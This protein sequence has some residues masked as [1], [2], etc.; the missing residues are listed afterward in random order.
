MVFCLNYIQYKV[1]IPS[2]P[3]QNK[4]IFIYGEEYVN[5]VEIE[6]EGNNSLDVK[7]YL[8]SK[9]NDKENARKLTIELLE[10]ILNIISYRFNISYNSTPI[11]YFTKGKRH[12]YGR[13]SSITIDM[14]MVIGDF[15]S[16]LTDSMKKPEL[17]RE[18]REN[19]YHIIF[20]RIMPIKD[21]ISKYLLLYSLLALINGDKQKEVDKFIKKNDPNYKVMSRIRT[22]GTEEVKSVYTTLRNKVGHITTNEE[23]DR[24][25]KDMESN[26]S[27]LI[28]LVKKAIELEHR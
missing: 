9:V 24:I 21:T 28:S 15:S 1:E 7:F 19:P 23:I 5:R 12:V 26:M 4:F 11:A 18:L 2:F 27:G 8:T 3:L 25:G 22:D 16:E 6:Q 17:I 20:R 13:D 10:N 14:K